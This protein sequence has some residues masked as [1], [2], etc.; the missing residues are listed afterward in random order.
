MHNKILLLET[1]LKLFGHMRFTHS[2]IHSKDRPGARA[3]HGDR[4]LESRMQTF[5]PSVACAKHIFIFAGG[6]SD[7]IVVKVNYILNGKGLKKAQ[8]ARQRY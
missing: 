3:I 6:K 4:Y 7:A 5:P 2:S 8:K 1:S